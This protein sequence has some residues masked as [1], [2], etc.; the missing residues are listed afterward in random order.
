LICPSALIAV[1]V[2]EPERERIIEEDARLQILFFS[3][4]DRD[5]SMKTI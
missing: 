3:F 5:R 4:A 1:I 2:D